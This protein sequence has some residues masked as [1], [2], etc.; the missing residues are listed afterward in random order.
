VTITIVGPEAAPA[1]KPKPRPAPGLV[2]GLSGGWHAFR[3]AL[4]WLLAIVGAAVPFAAVAAVLGLGAYL[5][6]R[7][8]AARV[9]AAG[10]GPAAGGDSPATGGAGG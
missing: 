3:V 9:R 2:N 7:R 6:R 5:A 10:G 1:P 8:L 4:S